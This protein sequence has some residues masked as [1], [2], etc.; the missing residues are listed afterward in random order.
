M[1]CFGMR[2]V[3]F[4]SG[5]Q[6]TAMQ[7]HAQLYSLM[8][9]FIINCSHAHEFHMH[10]TICGYM[11]TCIHLSSRSKPN[12]LCSALYIIYIPSHCNAITC[13]VVRTENSENALIAKPVHWNSLG[14]DQPIQ[15]NCVALAEQLKKYPR[16]A[17]NKS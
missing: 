15:P 12:L 2:L 8:L 13:I 10:F 9:F 7:L 16:H 4:N 6:F 1:L 11:R 17:E 5:L 3:V 14:S